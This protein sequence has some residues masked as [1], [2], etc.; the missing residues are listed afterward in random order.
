M[1]MAKADHITLIREP[2]PQSAQLRAAGGGT[3]GALVMAHRILLHKD[4]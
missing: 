3:A 4:A 1:H 2:S